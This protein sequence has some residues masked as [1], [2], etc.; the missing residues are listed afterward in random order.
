MQKSLLIPIFT[1]LLLMGGCTPKRYYTLGNNLDITQKITYRKPIDV[2]TVNVPK[3]LQ[4][5]ILVRQITPYQVELLDKAR[6]LTPMKKRLTNVLINY[7]QKSLNNPNV[8]LYPW[9]ANRKAD[10]R[11]EVTIKRFIAYKDK[12][13]LDADYKIYDYNTKKSITKLFSTKVETDKKIDSMMESMEKAYQQLLEE[14][15]T[16]IVK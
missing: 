12:V 11:V 16:E 10:K 14:I 3:Y 9:N 8:H 2:V 1:L 5:L 7:L 15:K 4:D 13:Y 6:W